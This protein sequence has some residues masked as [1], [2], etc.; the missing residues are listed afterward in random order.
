MENRTFCEECYNK[1]LEKCSFCLRPIND[2]ILR[3]TGKPFH[4]ECFNCIVCKKNLDGI[5]FTVDASNKIH[6]IECFHEKYAPRCYICRLPITPESGMEETIRIVAMDKNFHIHCYK[7]EDCG[8]SLSSN[9]ENAGGCFPLDDH[10][11]CK[12]CN[13]HHL[14]YLVNAQGTGLFPTN[15]NNQT[16][17]STD[18]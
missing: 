14:K 7:C 9:A 5:P 18:L 2:R 10:I 11:Y 12:N 3:A 16:P 13:Y 17:R 1:M 8:V 15:L 4:P 6:C